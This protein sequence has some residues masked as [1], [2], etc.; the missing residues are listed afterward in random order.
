MIRI[1]CTGKVVGSGESVRQYI[2]C[3]ITCCLC[4]VS[5]SAAAHAAPSICDLPAQLNDRYDVSWTLTIANPRQAAFS[6]DVEIPLTGYGGYRLTLS[7]RQ[8]KWESRTRPPEFV[9]VTAPFNLAKNDAALW[10]L[11]RR[12]QIIAL[13]YNH[14]L[15]FSA[16]APTTANAT[17]QLSR[18]PS[19]VLLSEM[20]YHPI[21]APYFGD[22]FMRVNAL[23][24]LLAGL[25]RWQEDDI[26]QVA[27]YQGKA[28]PG[29]TDTSASAVQ[30]NAWQLSIFPNTPTTTNG[31]WFLY[32]GI[33]PS[34]VVTNPYVA[35]PNWDRYYV[36]AAVKPDYESSVGLLA[37]YQD[38]DNYLRFRWHADSSASDERALLIAMIDGN[39]QTLA[40]CA[41]G[42]SPEQWYRLR[43]NIDWQHVEVLVDD[44]VLL[45]AKN[46]GAVEGRIGLFADNVK[47]PR[48][49]VIDQATS[50]LYAG[51]SPET[52]AEVNALS[53]LVHSVG[54]VY[55]DDL[56]VGEWL[57]VDDFLHSSYPLTRSG[58]WEVDE[59]HINAT[60]AGRLILDTPIAED[61]TLSARVA[62]PE[63][64]S[65][66]FYIHATPDGR[67][68][69]WTI[70]ANGHHLSPVTIEG[71]LPAVDQFPASLPVGKWLNIRVITDGPY[72]ACYADDLLVLSAYDETLSAGRVGLFADAPG[73]KF[74]N[75][76]VDF[77]DNSPLPN[78]R[79]HAGFA[80][81]RW[82]ATWASADADWTPAHIPEYSPIAIAN[83]RTVT[84]A[85]TPFPTDQPG[86]YW[87][88]GGHYGDLTVT[89]PYSIDTV[90]G[91]LLHLVPD[92]QTPG[93]QLSLTRAGYETGVLT[94]TRQG[95]VVAR[96]TTQLPVKGML[97]F[98]R[99]GSYLIL[100]LQIVDPESSKDY[101]CITEVRLLLTYRD[102]TPL[103][104]SR[105]GLTVTNNKLAA[106]D[107]RV[108]SSMYSETFEQSPTGWRSSSGLWAIMARYSCDPKWN[109]F[110]GFGSGT[111]AVW[112][113]VSLAGD[114]VVEA[115]LGVK[116]L[117]ENMPEEYNSRFRDLCLTICGDGKS[118][119]SGYAV[120][121]ATRE[122]ERQETRL[123]RH[124]VIVATSTDPA[125]LLPTELRGHRQWFA[126][127]IEKQGK[128]IRVYL[129][130]RLALT[131][132]DPEP[133]PG[134]HVAV[135]TINNGIMIGRINLS[136]EHF[137]LDGQ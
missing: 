3:A 93:Y 35:S 20:E 56:R 36:E 22:D 86:V 58:R 67:G 105:I 103:P 12:P 64:G 52:G 75:P 88:K 65:A 48:R 34:W 18:K 60:S 115:Y 125:H 137:V 28:W 15:V 126:T 73:V 80:S 112:S 113:K 74:D 89:M 45:V 42:F 50:N 47:N 16:P 104:A 55:F 61:Y 118:V 135:W 116:M 83:E 63:K 81:D 59:E 134:G 78:N 124:G 8:A 98:S 39:E 4:M 32:T 100:R 13:L 109:Y 43:I 40:A 120:Q 110:G 117:Y 6:L 62:I 92:S 2:A 27:Y 131:Y 102:P 54:C 7:A 96:A 130:N 114:Q 123:L 44:A 33:G 71:R 87:H 79:I 10:T 119:V 17:I 24:R 99:R 95:E 23:E 30:P 49:P 122:G 70:S 85:A 26:W 106:R 25:D 72:L 1:P 31:F 136:A 107:L 51:T 38:E 128:D 97:E 11:K 91:Q 37:A 127:R 66:G 41:Q 53:D 84:G 5:F 76:R 57:Y 94:L 121:R 9:A 82:L 101:P 133:L 21:D 132:H 108:L 68:Y 111:P 129:D 69:L 90:G 14:R 29:N 46:I 19:G 77:A